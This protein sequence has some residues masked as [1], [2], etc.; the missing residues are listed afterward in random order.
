MISMTDL[1]RRGLVSAPVAVCAARAQVWLGEPRRIAGSG[2]EAPLA[3]LL[4]D[5]ER[6]RQHAFFFERDALQYLL[7]H[8][9]LRLALSEHTTIATIAPAEWRFLR[10]AHGKPELLEQCSVP[11]CFSLSHTVGLVAVAVAVD[12][13]VGVDVENIHREVL[14]ESA[15]VERFITPAERAASRSLAPDAMQHRLVE[16]WTLKE[17]YA[18][19]RGLGLSLAFEGFGFELSDTRPPRI[20]LGSNLVDDGRTWHFEL[21]RPTDEHCLAVALGDPP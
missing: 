21:R 6:Q 9:L 7:A 12:C 3:E 10:T 20:R 1:Q 14:R 2:L 5:E 19:A 8:A 4:S 18:K 17:A 11:L 16:L 13:A 15:V